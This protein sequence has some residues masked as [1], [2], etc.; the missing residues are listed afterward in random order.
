MKIELKINSNSFHVT[1][2][3]LLVI[4]DY[5]QRFTLCVILFLNKF[6]IIKIKSHG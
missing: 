6:V 5:C 4:I 1:L 3:K 2:L